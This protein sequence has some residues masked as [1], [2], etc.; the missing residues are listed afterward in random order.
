MTI[1]VLQHTTNTCEEIFFHIFTHK[2]EASLFFLK[3]KTKKN[4]LV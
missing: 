2:H 1:N 3:Q 4:T